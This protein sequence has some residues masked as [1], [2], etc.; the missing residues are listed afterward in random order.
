MPRD[1]SSPFTS[2]GREGG[3]GGELARRSTISAGKNRFWKE[4]EE[5][6]EEGGKKRRTVIAATGISGRRRSVSAI[7]IGSHIFPTW[8]RTQR[9]FGGSI[10][11]RRIR[12]SW[13]WRWDRSKDDDGGGG[14]A[15]DGGG[16]ADEN[17]DGGG[18]KRVGRR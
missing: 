2:E 13:R 4:E 3:R 9:S 10:E 7:I 12:W 15:G 5:E 6:E 8:R 14:G 16:G 18:N 1:E 11:G 17:D